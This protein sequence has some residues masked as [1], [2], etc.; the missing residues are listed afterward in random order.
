MTHRYLTAPELTKQYLIAVTEGM[1]AL[2]PRCMSP[3]LE[4]GNDELYPGDGSS[5]G[6]LSAVNATSDSTHISGEPKN[7][8]H[9]SQLADGALS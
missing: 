6:F 9:L 2:F 7:A 3:R 1:R 8:K 4:R 5:V